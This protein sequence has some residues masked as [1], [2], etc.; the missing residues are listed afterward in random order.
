MKV[1][2][3]IDSLVSGG[4][5]RR[6]VELIKGF[7]NYADVQLHLVVFSDKIHYTEIYDLDVEVTIL[8]RIPKKNPMIFFK[9][10]KLCK[11][12]RPDLIHSWGTMSAVMAVPTS[13]LL[14][15]KLINGFIVDA[16]HNMKFFG[17]RLMRARLTFPFSKVVVGN[18][19]A[20]LKA[21]K[22]YQK[23]GVCI[24]NGFNTNRISNLVAPSI[25]RQKFNITAAKTVGMVATF[26]NRKDFKTF[27]EA[28][29]IVLNHDSNVNF[30]AVGHGENLEKCKN[31]VPTA[32]KSN[33]LF[34]GEQKDVESIVNI[35][36]IG[37]L[38]TNT[39]IHGEG[40]SNAILEYMA[41]GKPVIAT[42]GGGTNEIVEDEKTGYLI[43]TA[44]SEVLAERLLLLL[45]NSEL[46]QQLGHNGAQRIKTKFSIEKMIAAYD[47]LYRR[48][49]T[50]A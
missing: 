4:M 24:Y 23:K 27:I 22:V 1:M 35:F 26:T 29:L 42:A 37:V 5:E 11:E 3:L 25:I 16:S 32:F 31:M 40:I 28:G 17:E 38:A 21:Y 36:D 50:S 6:V 44:S 30:V 33:F 43:P 7:Q 12:W 39:E 14:R 18:S 34:T 13:V 49:L 19:I 47:Q 20:G 9:L 8:K 2:L 48:L 10:Y 41:L 15:I 46:A 45:K